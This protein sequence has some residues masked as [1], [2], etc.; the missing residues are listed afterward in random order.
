[1]SLFEGKAQKKLSFEKIAKELGRDEV[2]VAALFYGQAR[3]SEEDI[4]KLSKLLEID[5]KT[6][7][8]QLAGYPDRGR[9]IEMPPKDP[10]IYRLY[11]VVQNYGS[12]YKVSVS[13]TCIPASNGNRLCSM[14]SSVSTMFLHEQ[15]YAHTSTS[16]GDGIMSA[17]SFS[18]KVEKETDE[19]GDWAVITLRGKW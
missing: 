13:S 9:S 16:P 4:E 18:T 19:K 5:H 1:M 17:I 10:L 2:A 15:I 14:K 8:Q 3:A 7:A 6:L 12:A 11:E